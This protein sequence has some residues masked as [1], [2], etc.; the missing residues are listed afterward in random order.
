MLSFL[1]SLNR[2]GLAAIPRVKHATGGLAGIPAPNVQVPSY[3]GIEPAPNINNNSSNYSPK[4][5]VGIIQTDE[6]LDKF[7]NSS[8]SKDSLLK[9][10]KANP[11]EFNS[12][13]EG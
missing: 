6:Q 8:R 7:I 10:I 5:N 13:L 9:I 3:A 12:V 2:N 4:F 11:G 1:N